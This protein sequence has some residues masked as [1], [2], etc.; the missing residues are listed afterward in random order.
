ME[1]N[2]VQSVKDLCCRSGGFASLFGT[3]DSNKIHTLVDDGDRKAT[4]IWNAMIYQIAKSIGEMSVN[5]EAKKTQA[6]IKKALASITAF[7]HSFKTAL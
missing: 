6:K 2:G 7:F 3:S 4:L 1:K 5:T